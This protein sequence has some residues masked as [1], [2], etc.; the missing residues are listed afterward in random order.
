MQVDV[1]SY[2]KALLLAR[3]AEDLPTQGKGHIIVQREPRERTVPSSDLDDEQIA[4]PEVVPAFSVVELGVVQ[5]MFNDLHT[6]YSSAVTHGFFNA[7]GKSFQ[8][9][10]SMPTVAVQTNFKISSCII[11]RRELPRKH[12]LNMY[13]PIKHDCTNHSN[14][15]TCIFRC[16]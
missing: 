13:K 16:Q 7:L 12:E 6:K 4:N 8:V 15:D 9:L 5:H 10:V 11:I 14:R 1:H 3:E 2:R